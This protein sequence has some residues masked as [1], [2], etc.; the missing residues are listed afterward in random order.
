M[1][2][3]ADLCAN[4]GHAQISGLMC[5][6]LAAIGTHVT[7]AGTVGLHGA[8]AVVLTTRLPKMARLCATAGHAPICDW[9]A[10]THGHIMPAGGFEAE[11]RQ[12]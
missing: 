6:W 3:W 10:V 12:Q 1:L 2:K 9:L 11:S 4:A 5:D 7:P 8:S